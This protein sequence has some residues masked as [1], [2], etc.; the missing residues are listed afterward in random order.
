MKPGD[1]ILPMKDNK[2]IADPTPLI[3]TWR[4][5]EDCVKKGLVRSIGVSNFNKEQLEDLLKECTI[6]PVV[7]QIEFHPYI[8]SKT[9]VEF[10]H[11]NDIHVTAYSPLGSPDRPDSKKEDPSLMEDPAVISIAEKYSKSPAQILIRFAIDCGLAVIPKSKSED[12]IKDN[13]DVFDFKLNGDDLTQLKKLD[14]NFRY[15]AFDAAKSH[16]NYPFKN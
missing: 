3:D 2:P 14:R 8:Q 4:A 7:N 11:Q 12:R 1:E 15:I 5:L 6:K 9:L 16:P 10:C 13:L